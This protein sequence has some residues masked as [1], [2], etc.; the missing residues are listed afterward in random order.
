M[1][2]FAI[3]TTGKTVIQ[4]VVRGSIS[5][6]NAKLDDH[7]LLKSD[8]FPTYQLSAT[9]WAIRQPAPLLGQH[10]PEVYTGDLGL[11]TAALAAL[12]HDGVV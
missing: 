1:I 2:R 11:S 5:F 6:D 3:P 9:P 4:D 8:G 10:N 7:V 12:H